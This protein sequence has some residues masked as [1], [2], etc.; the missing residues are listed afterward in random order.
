MITKKD[1]Q[2]RDDI[3]RLINA[4]YDKLLDDELMAPLF[5]EVAGVRLQEHLPILYDFWQSV[6]FQAGKYSRDAMQPHLDLHFAHPLH[7]RHFERWLE[8][9]N[10]SVDE[11]FAGEKAHQAKVRALSIATVIR[12]KIHNLEKQRLEL[13]N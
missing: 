10:G 13:N 2:N 3:I 9:F 12:I 1:I 6:L 4:F 7:D 5:T 11:Q 8:L